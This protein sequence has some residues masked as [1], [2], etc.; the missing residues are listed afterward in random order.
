[1][2]LSFKPQYQ[3]KVSYALMPGYISGPFM[4]NLLVGVITFVLERVLSQK[5][6]AISKL[7][8]HENKII[9]K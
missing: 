8:F 4:D 7:S 1:M 3:N 5:N 9:L 6:Y 2:Q